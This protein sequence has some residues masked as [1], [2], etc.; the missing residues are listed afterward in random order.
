[1]AR[2]VART[3]R[4]TRARGAPAET[5]EAPATGA[6]T[7]GASDRDPTLIDR[8][9]VPSNTAVLT[10]PAFS[11]NYTTNFLD[12]L[13]R[14]LPGVTV[15]DQTGNPFQ[16]NLDYRG[17]I[18]S[19]V[20]GTPQGL[21]VYQNGVRIN[22]SWGDVVNWDF[23]PEKA[24]DRVTL[25][26]NNPVF[27]LNAIGGALSI[28]M[29][30]GFTY[31]GVEAETFGGSYGRVQ[32]GVQAG[33]QKDNVS[34]YAAFESAY[35]RGWR[36]FANSSHVNRM[37]V[38]VGARNDQTEFHVNFT[39]A[40][41]LLGNVAAT[42]IQMLNQR[43]SSVYTWPQSTHLQLAFVNASLSH[44]FSDT[45]SFQGNAYFRGF[46][47][48]HVDGNGTDVRP[49]DDP[50]ELCIGDNLPLSPGG[51]TPN[52]LGDA[53]LGEV[54]RN[55]VATNSFGGTAQLTNTD[56]LFGHDNHV[57][58][59]VSVDHGNTKFNAISELGTID[60]N[61]LFVTGTGVIINQPDA[62]LSPVDLRATN[63]YTGVYATDTFDV[64]NTLSVTAGG[65]FNLAQIDLQDQTGTNP[66]L[67][68]SNRFQR[69]N[70][71]IGATYKVTP[72]LTAYAGYSEANRAP[73]PLELGCSDPNHPCMIDTFLVADP[74]LKQVVA[75]TLEAGFRGGFGQDARTGVLTWGLGVF[76]TLS[77]DDIIQVTSPI[78][79]NNFG[80]FQNAGQTLRQGIEAK[81]EYRYDRWNA[82]ANYTYVNATYR[83]AITLFSPN[84]PNALTDPNND[85]VQFVNVKPGD[86]IPGIP[87]NRFKA[88]V[89]YNVT[90]AWKVGG[91][92]NFVGSQW[93]VH[94]DTNQSPKVPAYTVV[95]L[96][97]SYRIT[98]NVEIFGLINNVFN[99][100]YYL[101]GTFFES[102]GFASAG[103]APNL[104]AQLTDP[105]TFVPGTPLAAYAGI[106]ARF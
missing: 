50:A 10:A 41:N 67:N 11:H 28:Q 54:D 1:M 52:T 58:M 55:R 78:G 105:R 53:F 47:Q 88:G 8:D 97:S 45:W 59:G 83:T 61:N 31:Q 29:K 85:D 14:G 34:A 71:V 90:E 60:P 104:M 40:N 100:R 62:G 46:R 51:A 57:V 106:R 15:G 65:R 35:D 33:G 24:I 63:T 75:H 26:P 96:H 68:S 16:R 77:S 20:Q 101:G 3:S 82:Y 99:Q 44:N 66:L 91:D 30:N 93:L 21:A 73:T 81:L 76:R 70:P 69:F 23:I 27:G 98:P 43:W 37:Y 25:F 103:G 79:V 94:D 92:L 9:K 72:N 87:A 4:T 64:T 84:N 36:D 39:G 49:C 17:F 56:R 5:A 95:N 19:P 7:P 89:E 86:Q 22:E 42:P 12:A 18:A 74:P 13:V 102:G 6:A 48:S 2:P 32:G 80:F 38:D